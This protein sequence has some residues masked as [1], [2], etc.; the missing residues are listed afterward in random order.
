MSMTDEEQIAQQE[1]MTARA[2]ASMEE[3]GV[4]SSTPVQADYFG[5]SETHVVYLPDE[6]SYIEHSTLNEGARRKY[7]NQINKEVAIKK[8]SG[9]AVMRMQSGDDKHALLE[10]AIT[11]FN[12]RQGG[13]PVVFSKGSPG[14]TLSQ[15]LA[16]ADPKI[17]DIIEKDIRKFNPWLMAEMT[18][19]DIQ[20]QIDDLEEM[21][22]IKI[23]EEEGKAS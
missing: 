15:F 21:K 23:K 2:E 8:L 4:P 9:D 11:G 18:V 6:V 19:E 7:L 10:A 5:F 16:M 17:V 13:Q 20:K 22:D 12:L 14:S 1:E 3:Q